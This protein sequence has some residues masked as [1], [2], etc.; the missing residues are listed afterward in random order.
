M[1]ILLKTNFEPISTKLG[2]WRDKA[3]INIY[4]AKHS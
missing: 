3:I 1:E 4:A 2:S